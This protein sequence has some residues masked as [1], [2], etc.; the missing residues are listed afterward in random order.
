M[1]S[2]LHSPAM[3]LPRSMH[4]TVSSLF[5]SLLCCSSVSCL[6]PSAAL[7]I[8]C[9]LRSFAISLFL[10]AILS[11]I[12][13]TPALCCRIC[14]ARDS[15][16]SLHSSSSSSTASLR[17]SIAETARSLPLSVRSREAWS[18]SSLLRENAADLHSSSSCSFADSSSSRI[19]PISSCLALIAFFR[20]V[21]S[22]ESFAARDSSFYSPC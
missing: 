3:S 22:L 7:L 15:A 10:S 16:F 17:T 11:S 5:F 21:F 12:C 9:S 19:L 20:S 4:A 14:S 13:V 18:L 2:S 1:N 6:D 8:M